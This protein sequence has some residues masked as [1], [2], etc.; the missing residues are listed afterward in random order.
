MVPSDTGR[1]IDRLRK[2]LTGATRLD[3]LTESFSVFVY[4]ALQEELADVDLRLL[5]HG[6]SLDDLA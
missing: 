2:H 5:L 6:D 1:T 3:S 4:E